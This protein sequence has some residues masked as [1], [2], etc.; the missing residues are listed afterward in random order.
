MATRSLNGI[1]KNALAIGTLPSEDKVREMLDSDYVLLL[2]GGINASIYMQRFHQQSNSEYKKQLLLL[3]C[4]SSKAIAV[5]AL[6]ALYFSK[7]WNGE[8]I[9]VNTLDF[10]GVE[11]GDLVRFC[12]EKSKSKNNEIRACAVNLIRWY[13]R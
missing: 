8:Q 1:Y 12:L 3:C 9:D 10:D 11:Q 2:D 13:L 7:I 5:L 4:Y 6:R